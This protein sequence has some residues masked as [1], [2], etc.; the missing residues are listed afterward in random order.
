MNIE[1]AAIDRAN[2]PAKV[3]GNVM[4][5]WHR[6][7]S[8]DVSESETAALIRRASSPQFVQLQFGYGRVKLTPHQRCEWAFRALAEMRGERADGLSA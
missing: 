5:C 4:G 7:I 1:Q 2:F 6:G 8:V 3:L